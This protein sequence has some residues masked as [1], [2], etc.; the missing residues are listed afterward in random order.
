MAA[1]LTASDEVL[2]LGF[3]VEGFL[4]GPSDVDVYS[5]TGSPGTEIW[6]DIDRTSYTLDTVIELLDENGVVLAR[7]DNS[8][9]EIADGSDVTVLDA[10]LE[11]I[12]TSLQARDPLY[13][14]FGAGGL[15]EDFGSINPRDAGIHFTLTG[16]SADPESRGAYFFRV[17]SASINPDDA[18]GGLTRGGY[19]FQVRLAEDQEF[20]GSIVRYTDIRFANHGVHI[21]GLP[22]SSPLLGEAY[23]NEA[24]AGFQ[25]END[26]IQNSD[27]AGND[28]TPLGQRPQYLGNLTGNKAGV[29]SVGGVLDF[30]S[31][32]DFYQFDVDYQGVSGLTQSTIFDVDYADG[33]NRPDTNISVFYDPD[34]ETLNG[35]P[36]NEQ[37]RLVLFGSSSNILDDLTSPNGENTELEK[38]IRGSISSGDPFIGPVSLPEGT[39]Y[40]AI[41]DADVE[42][43]E[44]TSNVNL[45]REPINSVQRIVEDRIDN[46]S[47]STFSGPLLPEFFT[48]LAIQAS[49]FQQV[50]EQRPGHGKPTH[51]DGTNNSL[52]ISDGSYPES[53]VGIFGGDAPSGIPSADLEIL[54]WSLV[55]RADIGGEFTNV[56][57]N[58]STLFPHV[59][60]EGNIGSD[61]ADF[62]QFEVE[63]DNSTVILDIDNGFDPF[64]VDPGSI[65]LDMV[66]IQ[67]NPA[68]GFQFVPGSGGRITGS[69]P[70]DGRTGTIWDGFSGLTADPFIEINL[71]AGVY[72]VGII[73]SQ[74][75]F[76]FTNGFPDLGDEG[77]IQGPL[78]Y[79]LHVSV[80]NHEVPAQVGNEVLHFDRTAFIPS[81]TLTS[82]SFDLV[83]YVAEDLPMMYFN[84]RY[85][86]EIGDFVTLQVFSDQDPVGTTIGSGIFQDGFVPD[87]TWRQL[88]VPLEDFAGHTGIT[89][90]FVYTASGFSNFAAE[91]LYLDDFVVGFA[92]RGETVFFAR[93]GADGFNGFGQGSGEYQL[94]MRPA[95]EY[96]QPTFFGQTLAAD[97]DTNDRQS[98]SITIIAP[99][100]NQLSDGDTF[101]IGDGAANQTFEFTTTPG[102]VGFGNTQVLFSAIDSPAEIAEAIRTA[103]GQQTTIKI[104][105]SSASGKDTQPLDDA[106]LSLS[107]RARG[108][109]MPVASAAA[110][111]QPGTPLTT[112][113]D[114]NLLM[115]AIL[116]NGIGDENFLRTQGQV[117]VD[118]NTIRDVHAIGIWSEPGARDVD[119]DDIRYGVPGGLFFNFGFFNPFFNPFIFGFGN[120]SLLAHDFLQQPP[121]GNTYPG[122]VRNLPTL[123]DEVLGGLTPGVVITNNTVDQAGYAGV[124]ID[125]E[126]APWEINAPDGDSVGDGSLMIIDAAGTRVIFEFEDI[127]GAP[128]GSGVLGGD[129][130]GAGHVPIY[131]RKDC[132]CTYN[133][134]SLDNSPSNGVIDG[135]NDYESIEMATAIMQAIQGSILVT[136][137][138]V[139]L[140]TPTIGPSL[141]QM[142]EPAELAAL[143]EMG[144]PNASV[145]LQGASQ[146]YLV[147]NTGR[148]TATTG[149]R[150]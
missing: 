136:N 131:F 98:Q 128:G 40:V 14:E 46:A 7:S 9:A 18:A 79:T 125:G 115:P 26:R 107:G 13:T 71:D 59:S 60:I 87:N 54:D 121:I 123:N 86:P 122:A 120:R 10:R 49:D 17:R 142:S 145:Y 5:F 56:S 116:H 76:T 99:A 127:A 33:F 39:Y 90:E 134:R 83:G 97:F 62:Y 117:I 47:P 48:D 139:E 112:D 31:D 106:R 89:A 84:Y 102:T 61:Q 57:I 100:G 82:E 108:T 50:S 42:P 150:A 55:D 146:I 19:R 4:S 74:V 8:F 91:G 103:I 138:L 51:F 105:A 22:G 72:F 133:G 3:E 43:D 44:F 92:E 34:G 29:I 16:N 28:V 148:I 111:P 88:R 21:R 15:Y 94:E 58:T 75:G 23:E 129:G 95:T 114:G 2:R 35:E 80:E 38:L 1:E 37:A 67:V 65:D 104:E 113:A 147:G 93:G 30:G 137:D 73:Q 132:A 135:T 141:T 140:V 70:E 85:D 130:Y 68:G 20:P 25:A 149:S 144:F 126:S 109:F 36:F 41:T 53:A 24:I 124:K 110:A 12:T 66:L 118:A 96:L 81:G 64:D 11:G 69:E 78:D 32:V 27:A 63:T 143:D 45:R 119:P 6:V 77:A 101:V 52:I